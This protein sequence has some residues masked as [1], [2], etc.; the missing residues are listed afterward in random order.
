MK[1]GGEQMTYEVVRPVGE[2]TVKAQH[3]A[4]RPDTLDGKT[5]C[6]AYNSIFRGDITFPKIRDLLKKR[7]PEV[8][9]IPYTEMP[10]LDV[11][12]IDEQLKALPDV[13][14][15]KRCDALITGNGG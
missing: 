7:Y 6:E 13:L 5:I 9:I 2:V 14:S 11:V 8:N 1:G 12:R 10:T 4:A 15:Q 3:P